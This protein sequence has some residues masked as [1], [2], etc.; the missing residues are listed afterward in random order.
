M[1]I[2][3][4]IQIF[5]WYFTSMGH[6]ESSEIHVSSNFSYG[7]CPLGRWKLEVSGKERYSVSSFVIFFRPYWMCSGINPGFTFRYH[8]WWCSSLGT[9]WNAGDRN[10]VG[11]TKHNTLPILKSLQLQNREILIPVLKRIIL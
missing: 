9:L 3:I 5:F 6:I 4:S 2:C 10:Q 1:H 11:C 7:K 8:F